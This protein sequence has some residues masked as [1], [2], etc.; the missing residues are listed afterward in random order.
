MTLW[1]AILGAEV[2]SSSMKKVEEYIV[3]WARNPDRYSADHLDF[4]RNHPELIRMMSNENLLLPSGS[5]LEAIGNAATLGS[6]YPDSDR[7]LRGAIAERVG[8]HADNVVLG[9]GSTD[10]MSLA[11]GTFVSPGE[12]EISPTP[13]SPC[14]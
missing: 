4:A 14:A 2:T 6:L 3:P 1:T 12:T 11:I 5:V 10:L 13:R 9:N 7:Q 8:L